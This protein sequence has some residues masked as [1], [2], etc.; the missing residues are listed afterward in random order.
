MKEYL[1]HLKKLENLGTSLVYAFVGANEDFFNHMNFLLEKEG[2][3]KKP[4]KFK[5][6]A[7][8]H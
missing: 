8:R 5:Q 4:K 3:T 1:H 6:K 2:Y 7:E